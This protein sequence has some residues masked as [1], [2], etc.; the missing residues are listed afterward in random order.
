ML[1]VGNILWEKLHGEA[2][3]E[4]LK[5]TLYCTTL[6]KTFLSFDEKETFACH[7]L[8]SFRIPNAVLV[9]Q[10]WTLLSD[11]NLGT[12]RTPTQSS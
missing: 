7:A 1:V 12:A 11:P 9:I 10:I 8:K 3:G 4:I 6:W 5:A 2:V